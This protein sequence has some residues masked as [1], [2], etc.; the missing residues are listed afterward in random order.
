MTAK[1]TTAAKTA[2]VT[3]KTS[4]NRTAAKKSVTPKATEDVAVVDPEPTT[5]VIEKKSEGK[6]GRPVDPNSPRQ[7]M[8]AEKAKL[9]AEGKLK[10]GRPVVEGSKSHAKALVRAA[11]VA[12]GEDL[13]RGR[14]V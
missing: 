14:P 10:R 9:R 11:K 2:Q 8:L 13:K 4:A 3:T 6:L 7:I 1:K 5:P 12:A